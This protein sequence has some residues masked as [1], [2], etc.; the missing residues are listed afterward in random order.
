MDS[1]LIDLMLAMAPPPSDGQQGGGAQWISCLMPV[2]FLGIFYA[3]LIRPQQKQQKEHEKLVSEIKSGD[4]VVAAGMV[5]TIIT[6]KDESVTL[7]TGESKIEVVRTSVERVITEGEERP[8]LDLN[9][10]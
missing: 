3:L 10:K 1:S 5:G 6:V 2:A 8:S 9:K 7:R 4:R